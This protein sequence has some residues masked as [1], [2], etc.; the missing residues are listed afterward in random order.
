MRIK[1]CWSCGSEEECYE[2]CSCAKC[3]NPEGYAEWKDNNPEE[4]NAWLE[5]QSIEDY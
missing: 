1:P 2:Q 5:S 3:L 4:Y